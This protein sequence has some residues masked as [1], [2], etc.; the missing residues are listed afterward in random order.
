M[1]N[2]NKQDYTEYYKY[3]VWLLIMIMGV[4]IPFCDLYY[5]YNDNTC[6]NQPIDKL[7]INL[8]DYLIVYGWILIVLLTYV[9][10]KLFI[11]NLNLYK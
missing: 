10:I 3:V 8:K 9:S 6:V 7:S 2:Q 1:R 11:I 4:P 5:G